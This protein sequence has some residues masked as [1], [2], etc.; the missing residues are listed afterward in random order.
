M[1]IFKLL[2]EQT[3]L[4]AVVARATPLAIF[5]I[6]VAGF[7]WL[8]PVPRLEYVRVQAFVA[9]V[10]RDATVR[11]PIPFAGAARA[12][13]GAFVPLVRSH[14]IRPVLAGAAIQVKLGGSSR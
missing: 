14:L 3:I 12:L 10:A 4:D 11:T 5:H 13:D 6:V 9:A 2:S 1:N 7:A 8:D